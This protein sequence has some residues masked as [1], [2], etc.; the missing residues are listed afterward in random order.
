MPPCR[1]AVEQWIESRLVPAAIDQAALAEDA[2]HTS[3]GLDG[4]APAIATDSYR[5]ASEQHKYTPRIALRR[6][7]LVGDDH[8]ETARLACSVIER[9]HR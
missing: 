2:W 6:D 9:G 4:N 3:T 8:D 5:S 7:M 1:A